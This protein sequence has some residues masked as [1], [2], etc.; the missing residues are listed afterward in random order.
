MHKISVCIITF[1]EERNITDCL[2]SVMWADEIV[3]VDSGSTDA[4]VSICRE[5]TE[6]VFTQEWLGNVAQKNR[7]VDLAAN[8]WVFCIDADE[9]VTPLLREEIE[10]VRSGEPEHAGYTVPRVTWYC[11][12]WIKHGSWYPDRKLRLYARSTGRFKG[13][14]P[15][16]RVEVKGSVGHLKGDLLHYSYRDIFHHLQVINNY[17]DTRSK[18]KHEAGI[19]FPLLR[20]LFRPPAKFLK[21]YVLQCGFRDGAPGFIAAAMGAVYEL[22]KYAKLWEL[23]RKVDR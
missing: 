10:H 3:V 5:Y 17:T 14:D 21:M 16:D 20:M 15:H 1:N 18:L 9:R 2:Q 12:R 6:R 11:G 4:T 22:L 7:A 13:L 19:G 23:K 8:E